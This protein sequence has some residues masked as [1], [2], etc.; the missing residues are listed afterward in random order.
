MNRLA[1][2]GLNAKVYMMIVGSISRRYAK[3]LFNI[4]EEKGNLLGLLREAQSMADAWDESEVLRDTMTNPLVD[5]A[6]KRTIWN[7]IVARLGVSQIG[8]NFFNLL[9]DKSRFTNLP[10]I[11]RELSALVDL[12]ENRLRAEIASAVPIS[13]DLVSRLKSA[14]QQRTGNVVV[15]TSREDPS[16]IGGLVTKVGDLMYD[17]SLKTQLALMK[18]AMLDRG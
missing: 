13:D 8:K 9:F 10:G 1:K 16:L 7:D 6:T 3:A 2:E 12:K 18:E 14:L 4:G 17:G 15:I 11:A 5:V